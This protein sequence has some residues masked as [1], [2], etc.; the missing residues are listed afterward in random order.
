M[1]IGKKRVYL[2]SVACVAFIAS[3]SWAET[4]DD[5]PTVSFS[6][7]AEVSLGQFG[8]VPYCVELDG[9]GDVEILWLQSAGIFSSTVYDDTSWRNK[10]RDAERKLFCLTA[11]DGGGKVLWQL[12][13]PWK[14]DRPFLSHG[15]ERTLDCADIDGDGIIEVV[16]ARGSEILIIDGKQ[17]TIERSVTVVSDN[18][19][20][21]CLGHT[22]LGSADW[23]ILAKNHE[24]AYKPYEYANPTCF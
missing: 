7:S 12:G 11:T 5:S 22:G 24:R 21:I 19:R 1:K 13:R 16:C 9:D 2:A 3:H 10:I 17:G 15:N 18:I 20:T 6:L 14:G 4:G 8:G 23:T